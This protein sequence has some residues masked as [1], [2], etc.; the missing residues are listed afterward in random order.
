[1][2]LI[3]KPGGATP[4]ALELARILNLP[5]MQ[6]PTEED[7]EIFC[8]D[9]MSAEAYEAGERLFDTQVAALQ[10]YE[11]AGGGI[12]PI[13]VGW[14][15]SGISIMVAERAFQAGIKKILLLLP[16]NLAKGFME[17]HIPEWRQ[18]VPMSIPFLNLAGKA[19]GQRLAIAKSGAAGAYVF[20]YSLLS[21]PDT[22][23]ML[24]GIDADLVI[25]DEVHN[26][27]NHRAARV[28]RFLHFM[29]ERSK[30]RRVGFV[31]MSG[32]ITDKKISDYHHL[33]D[34]ALGD[35]SPIPRSSSMAFFWGSVLNAD[36]ENP[37]PE[38]QGIRTMQPLLSWASETFPGEKF[39]GDQTESYRRAYRLR[40]M[41]APGVVGSNDNDIGVSLLLQNRPAAQ[42]SPQLVALMTQVEKGLTPQNEPID[43]AIHGY[44]WQYELSSGF[45][46]ALLWPTVE[47]LMMTRKVGPSEA[48]L[49]LLRAKDHLRALQNYHK[50]VREFCK[51]AP[52]GLDTPRE[53]GNSI[54]RFG[55]RLVGEALAAAWQEVR[56]LDFE[57]R[58]E[59]YTQAVRLDDFKVRHAIEWAKEF[60]SGIIWVYHKELGLWISEA[61]AAQGLEVY[62]CPA[63]ADDLIESLGDPGRGAKGEKLVVASI[64]SHGTGRNL[65]AFRNQ[66]FAQWPRSAHTAEQTIGRL[67]RN[68]QEADALEVHTNLTLPFDHANRAATIGS[69]IYIQQTT[70]PRQKIIYCDY[71]PIPEMYSEEFLREGGFQPERL[72]AD[73]KRLIREK[74]GRVVA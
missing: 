66:L 4:E 28:N 8:F 38:N 33:M 13:G 41:S 24:E 40:I 56:A 17:R 10:G 11:A 35:R 21:V 67:H 57:G 63:G 37:H 55:G 32:T 58:P 9:R 27:K 31:G 16:P 36:A 47:R 26:L 3:K 7:V 71:D 61:I 14:G 72:T 70:G 68:G 69:A 49:L 54:A 59:R 73:M 60:G 23:P 34:F 29:R 51:R 22:M 30:V 48:E 25:A 2:G 1:M 46:N 20:P 44:K 52:A 45:Y 53:I 6:W 39:R 64:S 15:K 50:M 43:H 65:Q 42:P 12:F 19:A 74:F 18:R 5:V 62:H